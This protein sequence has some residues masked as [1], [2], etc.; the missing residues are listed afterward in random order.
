[1]EE[2][3][4]KSLGSIRI[5]ASRYYFGLSPLGTAVIL[6]M[7]LGFIVHGRVGIGTHAMGLRVAD[8]APMTSDTA[9]GP[10]SI[11]PFAMNRSTPSANGLPPEAIE[12]L[13]P[14]FTDFD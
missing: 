14:Y 11:H 1:M 9:D 7:A 8:Q 10:L 4:M 2:A 3:G 12:I 6:S 5:G 13:Q